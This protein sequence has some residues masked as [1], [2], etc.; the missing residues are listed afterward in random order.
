MIKRIAN[1]NTAPYLFLFLAACILFPNLGHRPYWTDELEDFNYIYK[2]FEYS[3]P[4]M[5]GTSFQGT[6]LVNSENAYIRNTW[7]YLYLQAFMVKTFGWDNEFTF[8]LPTTIFAVLS[9]LGVWKLARFWGLQG[10]WTTLL[11]VLS[12]FFL[13]PARLS[14]YYGPVLFF[15]P[16]LILAYF[17]TREGKPWSGVKLGIL[18]VLMFHFNFMIGLSLAIGL[19][20]HWAFT[21][22]PQI[23]QALHSILIAFIPIFGWIY[24]LGLWENPP[25][26]FLTIPKHFIKAIWLLLASYLPLLLIL[27]LWK[28][29]TKLKIFL[30]FNLF[31]FT[32]L[33]LISSA[34]AASG[35]NLRY[36]LPILCMACCALGYVLETYSLKTSSIL[37]TAFL[38]T[39]CFQLFPLFFFTYIPQIGHTTDK[40]PST[41]ISRFLESTAKP[42]FLLASYLAEISIDYKAPSKEIFILLKK[43]GYKPGEKIAYIGYPN[44]PK[45]YS[46]IQN[47][48]FLG[49][50]MFYLN[51]GVPPEVVQDLVKYDLGA[52]WVFC[53]EGC[54][55][56]RISSDYKLVGSFNNALGFFI[57]AE[58]PFNRRYQTKETHTFKLYEKKMG[59][60]NEG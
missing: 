23:K 27:W 14:R 10:Y 22:A 48:Y 3:Y 44:E 45:V 24:F 49:N 17:E 59:I 7:G 46:S 18:C 47:V 21:G 43:S 39:N 2:I 6:F 31:L 28:N 35:P 36:L 38:F 8:R 16:F 5:E 11:Y 20:L 34:S 30:Q 9:V 55:T 4:N 33:I 13:V 41:S 29:K 50:A 42:R 1:S 51:Q 19:V 32:P 15:T 26:N 54:S 60:S 40:T 57:D 12:P 37:G 53:S 58:N 25:T 52:K 56:E